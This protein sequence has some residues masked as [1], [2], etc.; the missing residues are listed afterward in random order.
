[1]SVEKDIG[2]KGQ[3]FYVYTTLVYET[4]GPEAVHY[5]CY[6]IQVLQRQG[7]CVQVQPWMTKENAVP[8]QGVQ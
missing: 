6:G 7:H 2:Q 8:A 5:S 3:L 1:M 4:L